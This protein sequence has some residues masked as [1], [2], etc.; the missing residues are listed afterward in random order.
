MR[1]SISDTCSQSDTRLHIIKRVENTRLAVYHQTFRDLSSSNEYKSSEFHSNINKDE[2]VVN[3]LRIISPIT[4][5]NLYIFMVLSC[6]LSL[7][8]TKESWRMIS[9]QK[10]EHHFY[11]TLCIDCMSKL[12]FLEMML[13]ARSVKPDLVQI[14]NVRKFSSI[15]KIW[16]IKIAKWSFKR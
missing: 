11:C 4:V 8:V 12:N 15:E 14:S 9:L 5:C 1:S 10:N 2:K 16:A 13:I 6:K 3:T 7:A